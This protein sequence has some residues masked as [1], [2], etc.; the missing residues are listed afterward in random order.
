M[1]VVSFLAMLALL[2]V[3]TSAT[4]TPGTRMGGT[5]PHCSTW[6]SVE[7]VQAMPM[8]TW[9]WDPAGPVAQGLGGGLQA[10]VCNG[11]RS[12]AA[13][14]RRGARSAE[15]AGLNQSQGPACRP[16]LCL[17]DRRVSLNAHMLMRLTCRYPSP[18]RASHA[19]TTTST[20]VHN[21]LV[22]N[23]RSF[24][25]S[26]ARQDRQHAEARNAAGNYTF[27]PS[28]LQGLMYYIARTQMDDESQWLREIMAIQEA[29][30][31]RNEVNRWRN[32]LVQHKSS[33]EE[34]RHS[35]LA[36]ALALCLPS[37][38][39]VE[40]E[41]ADDD[42]WPV[43]EE[44]TCCLCDATEVMRLKQNALLSCSCK[45]PVCWSCFLVYIIG[46][47][48]CITCN[49]C[50]DGRCGKCDLCVGPDEADQPSVQPSVQQT[51]DDHGEMEDAGD[52]VVGDD[53][54]DLEAGSR[55]LPGE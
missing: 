34:H 46:T 21:A 37:M 29:E 48:K 31:L 55:P 5:A 20:P 54:D 16:C 1:G 30:R 49:R 36:R 26:V 40:S 43:D 45:R 51:A 7:A 4:S 23:A 44:V 6:E 8:F 17:H 11:T 28:Q 13:A 52:A 39:K 27:T 42:K 33:S 2:L 18:F 35:I 10:P 19:T 25:E 50:V 14:G 12:A 9:P 38:L 24:M 15:A 53:T 3:V 41:A 47:G 22:E 32:A